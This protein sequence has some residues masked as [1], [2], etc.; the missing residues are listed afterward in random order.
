MSLREFQE[1]IIVFIYTLHTDIQAKKHT[2][3]CL[4]VSFKRELLFLFIHYTL[5][6]KLK[7]HISMSLRE[8]QEK[9][10]V[11]IYT[12]HTAIQAKKHTFPCLYVSFKRE[13]LFLF[14]HY[15]LIFKLRNTHFHVFT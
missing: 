14:I 13:L 7:K 6:F 11:F 4:Y 9:I 1:R 15:T 2:F 10:I 8:F 3:P 5:I 12:L